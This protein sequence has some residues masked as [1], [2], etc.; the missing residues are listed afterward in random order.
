MVT[1]QSQHS[2]YM[3]SFAVYVINKQEEHLTNI[4]TVLLFEAKMHAC[5]NR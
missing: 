3:G 1:I 5:L 4:F 2:D